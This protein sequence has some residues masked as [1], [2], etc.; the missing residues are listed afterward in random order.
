LG[1]KAGF[2]VPFVEGETKI[3][4]VV[5]IAQK[6]AEKKLN[7]LEVEKS[8]L[9]SMSKEIDISD[10]KK[11][12]REA[13]RKQEKMEVIRENE[14]EESRGLKVITS[15]KKAITDVD[16]NA[17]VMQII[18]SDDGE[19]VATIPNKKSRPKGVPENTTSVLSVS[20]DKEAFDAINGEQGTVVKK[21]GK[22]D[23]TKEVSSGKKLTAKRGNAA[24]SN[25]AEARAKANAEARKKASEARRAKAKESK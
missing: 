20:N 24:K 17:K 6:A 13:N 4:S 2:I 9:D 25:D 7:K 23:N 8:D 16:S 1:I 19:I 22:S 11:E 18:N 14:A 15:D 10:T 21:I 3:N 5:K 12:V